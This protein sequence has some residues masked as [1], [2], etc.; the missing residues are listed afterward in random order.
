ML[1]ISYNIFKNQIY[2]NFLQFCKNFKSHK[3]YF[4]PDTHQ[5]THRGKYS[6][7]YF[8]Q[9]YMIVTSSPKSTYDKKNSIFFSYVRRLK[10]HPYQLFTYIQTVIYQ[11]IRPVYSNG[12]IYCLKLPS[13]ISQT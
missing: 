12:C 10:Y 4:I 13:T 3:K 9:I 2:F 5:P 11:C 1:N 6:T 8:H 7:K